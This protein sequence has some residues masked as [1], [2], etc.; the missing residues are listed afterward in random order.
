MSPFMEKANGKWQKVAQNTEL[1]RDVLNSKGY[2][3]IGSYM[4]LVN[5]HTRK[6]RMSSFFTQR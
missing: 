5:M 2:C 3:E 4:S 1:A 6:G